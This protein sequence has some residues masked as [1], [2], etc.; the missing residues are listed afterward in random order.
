MPTLAQL[1]GSAGSLG[2]VVGLLA[3]LALG[4]GV[5]A[6]VV[7]VL[8]PELLRAL[9]AP[10]KSAALPYRKREYLFTRGEAE[11]YRAMLAGVA[12]RLVV[13]GKVRMEDVLEVRGAGKA[14][15]SYQ[16]RI[17]SKHFDFV[18]CEPG[19]MRI[20]AA[21]ELDDSSHRRSDRAD[22]DRFVDEACRGAG[23]VLVRFP[24][25]SKY[26]PS[27]IAREI[28]RALVAARPSTEA[29]AAKG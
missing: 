1:S 21:V 16:N 25:A 9:L 27:A 18:L 15:Q 3:V 29:A 12:G 11:F 22:R 5:L 17:R 6:V 14:T 19:S 26:D 8:R 23:L 2:A 20:L 7:A 13:S 4:L 28:E 10:E 24:A